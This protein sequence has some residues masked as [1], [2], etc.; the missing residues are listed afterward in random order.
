MGSRRPRSSSTTQSMLR[1]SG[2]SLFRMT[3]L[4]VV[5][6]P[7]GPAETSTRPWSTAQ[8]R[9]ISSASG[10]S[11]TAITVTGLGMRCLGGKCSR[12]RL[13]DHQIQTPAVR[14]VG[15]KTQLDD[16]VLAG[17]KRHR[18]RLDWIG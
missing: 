5:A 7:G 8:A 12:R 13:W 15:G 6:S 10:L 18:E 14:I 4:A 2:Y 17:S 3:A 1:M 9:T 16:G 11:F